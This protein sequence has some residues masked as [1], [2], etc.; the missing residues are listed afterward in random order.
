LVRH[1][2]ASLSA[3]VGHSVATATP[4]KLVTMLYDRMVLDLLRAEQE[5]ERGNT[6]GV[7]EHLTHAQSILMELQSSLVV[8]DVW[9]ASAGLRSLYTFLLT[10]LIKANV[11]RSVT[12]TREC[13]LLLEPLR[14][15][16]HEASLMLLA[17]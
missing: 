7:G 17:A 11:T 14:D 2:G 5:F 10:E 16:W 6:A 15:A 4:A 1:N 13:R 12:V 9:P 8:D 3:Y